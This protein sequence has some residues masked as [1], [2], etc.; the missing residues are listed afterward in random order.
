MNTDTQ[1]WINKSQN[2]PQEPTDDTK[3][4]KLPKDTQVIT[5]LINTMQSVNI[6][7]EDTKL[8]ATSIGDGN[9]GRIDLN[10]GKRIYDPVFKKG[11]NNVSTDKNE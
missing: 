4:N 10:E 11:N 8:N 6:Q 9:G 2:A 5:E 3:S 1:N 7:S